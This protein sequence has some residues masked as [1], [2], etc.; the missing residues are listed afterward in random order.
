MKNINTETI[1]IRT[2]VEKYSIL[3]NISEDVWEKLIAFTPKLTDSTQS[4][5]ADPAY[6]RSYGSWNADMKCAYI[7]SIFGEKNYTPIVLAIVTK[8]EIQIKNIQS[9]LR[10]ACLDGQHRSHTICEFVN[11]QFGF[12]GTIIIDGTPRTYSS[13][14]Y[15][16]K[17]GKRI[18]EVFLSQ[19]SIN[20]QQVAE[21]MDKAEIFLRL[22]AGSG[23][24]S[25]EKRNAIDCHIARWVQRNRRDYQSTFQRIKG[26]NWLR[27]ADGLLLSRMALYL[28]Q[29]ERPG[30]WKPNAL[31][32]LD[33]ELNQFYNQGRKNGEGAY[34]LDILDYISSHLLPS[35]GT[36]AEGLKASVHSNQKIAPE[37]IWCYMTLH[38]DLYK[39]KKLVN[40]DPLRLYLKTQT[41]MEALKTAS[42]AAMAKDEKSGLEIKENRYFHG[43]CKRNQQGDYAKSIFDSLIGHIANNNINLEEDCRIHIPKIAEEFEESSED[44]AS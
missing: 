12:K 9:N 16:S 29:F 19:R 36:I 13:P 18:Q 38:H 43:Y 7:E 33:P 1:S 11:N 44:L 22:N 41:I 28:T 24:N 25:Q 10:Y 42:R 31:T 40:V 20:I 35:V 39:Q 5:Y 17:L 8:E 6:Q 2:F 26:L 23:L 30:V 32:Q 3:P 21:H 4:Q 27:M 37:A 15:F 14:V 34:N